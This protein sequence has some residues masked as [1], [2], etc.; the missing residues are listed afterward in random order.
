MTIQL[1]QIIEF[2][3]L[4]GATSSDYLVTQNMATSAVYSIPCTALGGS[5]S[6]S[7]LTLDDEYGMN[8]MDITP[9]GLYNVTTYKN[10]GKTSGQPKSFNAPI[11][12]SN[13]QTIKIIFTKSADLAF[14]LPTYCYSSI[15]QAALDSIWNITAAPVGCVFEITKIDEALDQLGKSAIFTYTT[16]ENITVI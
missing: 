4:G 7:Q 14:N 3:S 13:G 16:L 6:Y 15:S 8:Y 12:M 9:N 10:S 5:A 2:P 1:K 11:N